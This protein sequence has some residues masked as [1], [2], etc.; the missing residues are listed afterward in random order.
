[1]EWI[2][3]LTQEDSFGVTPM[4]DRQ[5]PS[6]PN[7]AWNNYEATQ[8]PTARP[9]QPQP[10]APP[11]S[12]IDGIPVDVR[13]KIMAVTS[14]K[15]YQIFWLFSFRLHVILNFNSV[16][17]EHN[18][19]TLVGQAIEGPEAIPWHVRISVPPNPDA[20]TQSNDYCSG[21]LLS[22][23]WVISTDS[24]YGK[25]LSQSQFLVVSMGKTVLQEQGQQASINS[26]VYH[27]VRDVVLLQLSSKIQF[28]TLFF[29]NF[30][31][32]TVLPHKLRHGDQVRQKDLCSVDS[33][34]LE[35][36]DSC[37]PNFSIFYFFLIR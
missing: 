11:M 21:A 3:A 34:Q 14:S 18:R 15:G 20:M 33:Q 19:N 16:C 10:T 35:R 17:G 28:F 5:I 22:D 24:C 27:Q 2:K 25:L 26:A 32:F 30:L 12:T 7:P 23:N 8:P 6:F 13:P 36:N 37:V 31:P 1:M 9:T 29:S 4:R